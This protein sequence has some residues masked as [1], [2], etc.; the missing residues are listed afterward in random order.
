MHLDNDNGITWGGNKTLIYDATTDNRFEFNDTVYA[1]EFVTD[2]VKEDNHYNP[3]F[4]IT[5]GTASAT[6]LIETTSD[7]R[8]YNNF[9]RISGA[10]SSRTGHWREV[11][12]EDFDSWLA[13][14]STSI[15]I[16]ANDITTQF[17]A[18]MY[19]N[20]VADATINGVTTTV[21]VANTWEVWNLQPGTTPSAGDRINLYITWTGNSNGDTGDTADMYLKW[22][23]NKL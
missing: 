5:S 21:A 14:N 8:F 15:S 12:P 4:D 6:I 17:S 9:V 20:G 18:T 1:P 16:R 23:G 7:R 22:N 11:I 2:G 3:Y 10:T 19:I 13:G